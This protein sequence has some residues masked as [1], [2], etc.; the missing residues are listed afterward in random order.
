VHA[1]VAFAHAQRGGENLA[2]EVAAYR[3][4]GAVV[5]LHLCAVSAAQATARA[6]FGLIR[7]GGV[8]HGAEPAR[9]FVP[10]LLRL[11][12]AFVGGVFH[13]E[14]PER[15]LPLPAFGQQLLDG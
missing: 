3:A 11:D 12:A 4:A 10:R 1:G 15:S 2:G 8:T 5:A 13:Y 6:L 7:G 9:H 14:P